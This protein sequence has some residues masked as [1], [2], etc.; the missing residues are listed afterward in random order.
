[1]D[2]YPQTSTVVGD[3]PESSIQILIALVQKLPEDALTRIRP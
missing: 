2:A 3:S 1:M